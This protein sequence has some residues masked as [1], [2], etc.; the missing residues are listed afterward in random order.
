MIEDMEF[1]DVTVLTQ[2]TGPAQTCMVSNSLRRGIPVT[3][4][5]AA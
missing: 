2:P 5:S 1:Y 4:R 3:V